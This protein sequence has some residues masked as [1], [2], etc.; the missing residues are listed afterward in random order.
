MAAANEPG[1]N[2]QRG[3]SLIGQEKVARLLHGNVNSHP[4]WAE[5]RDARVRFS[6]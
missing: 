1:P 5:L 2:P 4:E 6:D 3:Y